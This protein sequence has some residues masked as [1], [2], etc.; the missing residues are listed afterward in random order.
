MQ[1]ERGEKNSIR[2]SEEGIWNDCF[3]NKL[4]KATTAITYANTICWVI[5]KSNKALRT[6]SPDALCR[7]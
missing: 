5:L 3:G 2:F 6:H 7:T 1:T 4:V